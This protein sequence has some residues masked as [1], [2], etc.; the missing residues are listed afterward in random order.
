MNDLNSTSRPTLKPETISA[1]GAS[2][3]IDRLQSLAASTTASLPRRTTHGGCAWSL[4]SRDAALVQP[5]DGAL[6][7][8]GHSISSTMLN[9]LRAKP[10][11]EASDAKL[12]GTTRSLSSRILGLN[13]MKFRP[14]PVLDADTERYF[15]EHSPSLHKESIRK[16]P[17]G[18]RKMIRMATPQTNVA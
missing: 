18:T 1:T 2:R 11:S 16:G 9:A 4:P 14:A 15:A 8:P 3:L 13:G 17:D 6:T 5:Q 10:A 12:T 7:G